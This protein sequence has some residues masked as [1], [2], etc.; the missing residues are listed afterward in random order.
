MTP[1]GGLFRSDI[2]AGQAQRGAVEDA[3]VAAAVDEAKGMAGRGGVQ[4]APVRVAAF[5]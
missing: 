4:V 1:P 5:L 3:G 2:D